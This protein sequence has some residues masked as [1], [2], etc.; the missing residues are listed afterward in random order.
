MH[1]PLEWLHDEERSQVRADLYQACDVILRGHLHETEAEATLSSRGVV[2]LAAGACYQGPRWPCRAM[3]VTAC[4]ETATLRVHPIC[5]QAAGTRAWALDT[6]VFPERHDDGYE[7]VLPL[8]V[9][10]RKD[11][12]LTP[13]TAPS[14]TPSGARVSIHERVW[15]INPFDGIG[16]VKVTL[17]DVDI[18]EDLILA[19]PAPPLCSVVAGAAVVTPASDDPI[20]IVEDKKLGERS[21]FILGRPG[22]FG[23]LEWKYWLSNGLPLTASDGRQMPPGESAFDD[24]FFGRPHVVRFGCKEL[25]IAY[26]FGGSDLVGEIG[27]RAERWRDIPGK[28]TWLYDEPE[29]V[30][31]QVASTSPGRVELRVPNPLPGHRYT[32][33]YKPKKRGN[34]LSKE[35]V[36]ALDE[37]RGKC[38][39]EQ[40]DS[41]V[42]ECLT[43]A[44]LKGIRDE[45]HADLLPSTACVGLLWA[46]E[47]KILLPCF[48]SF[49]NQ[50]WATR[51]AYG[52]GV[53]GHAFRFAR[54]AAWVRGDNS[55]RSVVYAKRTD[56]GGP[57]SRE[58]KWVVC[59]PLV[60]ERDGPAAG[61]VSFASD[62][63]D[64]DLDRILH[65]F[66]EDAGHGDDPDRREKAET[67]ESALITA[68]N[69]AV[70]DAIANC[71]KLSEATQRRAAKAVM[72]LA[73]E[74]SGPASSG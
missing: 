48:G 57:Y 34:A 22:R 35:D 28:E 16:D 58:Y 72:A 12:D 36:R 63:V 60:C 38:R 54:V 25:V 3:Y 71:E 1:H 2:H 10:G 31:C 37:I 45:F 11:R 17:T 49:P 5:Y 64:G 50:G 13:P 29:T 70:W 46:D 53:A 20:Q 21:R 51:F 61:I 55:R 39:H 73:G 24:G 47:R 41:N 66:A 27:K 42:V 19:V 14:G 67:T 15:H 52:N 59:V 18:K 43:A 65:G 23:R 4:L 62:T 44:L 68:I 74:T 33:L 7:A 6:S 26:D 56:E 40:R 32:L 69:T 30:R 9:P 8:R